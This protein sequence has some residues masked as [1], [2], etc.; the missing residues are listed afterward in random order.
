MTW[1]TIDNAQRTV[2]PKAGISVTFLV[3]CKLYYGD[4][5]LHKV[6]RKYLKQ[7]SSYREDINI[8]Q[9][10]LFSKFNSK[11]RLTRVC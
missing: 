8:L 7:F 5:H 2:T 9:K 1:I 10:S 3:F 6:S 11:S 4:I